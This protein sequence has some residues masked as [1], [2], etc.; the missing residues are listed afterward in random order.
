MPRRRVPA[1][2]RFEAWWEER[3]KRWADGVVTI[4]TVLQQRAIDLGCPP[5]RVLYL[6]TGA[7]VDRIRPV[8][9]R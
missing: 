8:A 5:D 2:G 3:S 9:D 6:P 4:S 7:A 1:V